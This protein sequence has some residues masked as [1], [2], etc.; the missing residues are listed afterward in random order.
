MSKK[1]YAEKLRDPRW[2]KKRL[3]VLQRDGWTCQRCNAKDKTLHV[4][5]YHYVRGKEPWE[6]ENNS[7]VTLCE[8]C[9]EIEAS[10][11]ASIEHYLLEVLRKQGWL[12]LEIYGLA[13]GLDKFSDG[14]L[15][16]NLRR[17]IALAV[18]SDEFK[19]IIAKEIKT[20]S[21]KNPG[22]NKG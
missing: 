16:T 17:A 14:I 1:T 2:Q 9:H 11:L 19:E 12:T 18:H 20:L 13:F 6:Y 4:H 7:L 10:E 21:I 3:E 22:N 8:R 15:P 5:H